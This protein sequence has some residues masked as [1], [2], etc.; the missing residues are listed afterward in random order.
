MEN[1]HKGNN[2]G[3]LNHILESVPRLVK[4]DR[5]LSDVLCTIKEDKNLLSQF[6]FYNALR[7]H[8]GVTDSTSVRTALNLRRYLIK[9]Y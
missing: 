2:F 6:Q 5:N 7:G 9:I 8:N 4:K 1:E 3:V